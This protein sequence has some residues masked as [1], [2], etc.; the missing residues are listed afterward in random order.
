MKIAKLNPD[1]SVASVFNARGVD[2]GEG[3]EMVQYP[4]DIFD[5][6]SDDELNEIGFAH[7]EEEHV[8]SDKRSTGHTD[9]FTDGRIMRTHTLIDYVAPPPPPDPVPGDED[10]DYAA[11]RKRD[12][13]DALGNG[14]MN[15]AIGQQLDVIWKAL[16]VLQMN[17][18]ID[19]PAEAD[20]MVGQLMNIKGKYPKPDPV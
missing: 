10:Y 7:F 12:I 9:T 11:L 5:A 8:P 17:G 3:D 14:D 2:V 16:N 18:T 6:W 4:S 13:A 15:E 20:T 19:L 1:N